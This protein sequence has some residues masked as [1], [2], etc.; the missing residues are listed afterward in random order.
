MVTRFNDT[1]VKT[2]PDDALPLTYFSLAAL[3]F[4]F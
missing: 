1:E 3:A 2:L 4:Y